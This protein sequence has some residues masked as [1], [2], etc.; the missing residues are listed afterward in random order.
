VRIYLKLVPL[1]LVVCANCA[2]AQTKPKCQKLQDDAYGAYQIQEFE[3]ALKLVKKAIK[4]DP[5]VS[6]AYSLQAIIYETMNDSNNAVTAYQKCIETDSLYQA[7]YYYYANYL[8]RLKRYNEALVALDGYQKAPKISGYKANRDAASQV[9][10]DKATRLKASI[11][12][13]AKSHFDVSTLNISNMGPTINS[14]QHEYWPGMPINGQTFVFTRLV[15]SQEDFYFSKKEGEEWQKAKAAPGNINTPENEGTTSVFMGPDVEIL[16]YTV[17]NQGGFGSCDL[18]YS[19]LDKG[20]WGAKMNLGETINSAFW[21]AQPSVSGDGNLLIFASARPGGYGGKDLWMA[22]KYNGVWTKPTNLGPTINTSLD[23][24]APFLHYDGKT[25]YFSSVGHAGFGN[26]DLFISRLDEN[27]KWSKPE[28]LG[29]TVNTE[30][31]DVGFYVDA[32]GEKAYFASGRKGGYGGLDIYSM[33]LPEKLKPQ[34]VNYL[35]GRVLDKSN[36]APIR[37]QV[38]LV[39]LTTQKLVY[40]DSVFQ[41]LI[42]II[43]GKNYALHSSCQGYLFDSRNFQPTK[44]TLEEPFEVNALLDK[45]TTD[46]TVVLN[47]IFFDIDKFDIKSESETELQTVLKLLR[48]NPN[49]KIEISGHTDITG[50]EEHNKTLSANRANSIKSYLETKGISAARLTSKGYG[51]TKPNAS[52]DTEE[53]RALNRRIEIK[54]LKIN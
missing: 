47:N 53:G 21:D 52:N 30:S 19:K 35:L 10:A 3:I 7:N 4:C 15:N 31:D 48:V 37:A 27:D 36:N 29:N 45:I 1:V 39:D 43:P 25:L 14:S 51:S 12:M 32:V 46:Q 13:A 40:Q 49:M 22:R 26:H 24:E 9:M 8:F 5:S 44:S 17:C 54:I 33:S 11:E 23:E 18:F 20:R 38:R 34:P 42:P 2:T 28:N 16:Y 41:F 6:T 50:S